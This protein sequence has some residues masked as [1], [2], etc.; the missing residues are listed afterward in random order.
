MQ[1]VNIKECLS[2]ADCGNV[3]DH[4]QVAGIPALIL[5]QNS[6]AVDKYDLR[7]EMR[8]ICFESLEQLQSRW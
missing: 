6:V 7:P 2:A 1:A 4:A 3:E 8:L 5:M